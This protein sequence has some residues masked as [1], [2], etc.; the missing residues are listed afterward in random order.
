MVRKVES[1]HLRTIF[2]YKSKKE[3]TFKQL[4]LFS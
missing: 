1:N 3:S 4:N 2:H